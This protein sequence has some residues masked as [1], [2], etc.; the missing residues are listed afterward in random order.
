[1]TESTIK[2]SGKPNKI[3]SILLGMLLGGFVW[4]CRGAGGFGSFWGMTI[5]GT[6][7]TLLIFRFYG[8]RQKLYC[9]L[10]PVGALLAGMT[11]PSW[12]S[13]NT[14]MGGLVSSESPLASTGEI[15][16]IDISGYR[17][18]LLMFITGFALLALFSVFVGT[19][20]SERTYKLYHYVILSTVFFA[21]VYAGRFTFSH[22]LLSITAPEICD[23]F[24]EG[25][26][27]C[28][29]DMSAREGYMHFYGNIK[30]IKEIPY[31]RAYNECIDHFSYF[32]ASLAVILTTFAVFRDKIAGFSGIFINLITAAGF[33]VSDIFIISGQKGK[34]SVL[35]HINLPA[36]LKVND[37]NLWEYF[38]GFFIGLSIMLF[39]ALLPS[40]LTSPNRSGNT[41][42]FKSNGFGFVYNLVLTFCFAI[43]AVPVRALGMRTGD[44]LTGTGI[45]AES[46]DDTVLIIVCVLLSCILVP[47]TAKALR[48]NIFGMGVSFRTAPDT[49]ASKALPL[50]MLALFIINMIPASTFAAILSAGVP[51]GEALKA[52][53]IARPFTGT[54]LSRISAIVY[55][56]FFVFGRFLKLCKG[57]RRKGY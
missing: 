1:M 18:M 8:G 57:D 30:G 37:W 9:E 21:V 32:F 29:L 6:V 53:L 41:P 2:T 31:G 22:N 49:F 51:L 36:F 42:A 48:K 24:K 43:Y 3:V 11:T 33:T 4:N 39:I 28:G 12:G 54:F 15:G 34:F 14:Y 17:G 52:H 38:T 26:K 20:F 35:S 55:L 40:R 50:L 5:V 46:A 56:I 25:L 10:I 27:S 47:V 13:V 7:I 16:A 45:L 44:L 23:S 19:L